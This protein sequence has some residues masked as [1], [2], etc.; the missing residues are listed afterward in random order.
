[1]SNYLDCDFHVC[2]RERAGVMLEERGEGDAKRE[3][4][5]GHGAVFYDQTDPGTEFRLGRRLRERV[6]RNAFN[7]AIH[8][9]DDV[10][11]LF[12]H[13][14]DFLLAR[15]ASGTLTLSIDSRGLKYSFPYDAADADHKSVRSKMVRGDLTGSSFGFVVEKESFEDDGDEIIRTIEAVNPLVDVSPVTFPAFT[16]AD[17]GIKRRKQEHFSRSVAAWIGEH[18]DDA[19]ARKIETRARS[20]FGWELPTDFTPGKP[21]DWYVR[22]L[23]ILELENKIRFG[24][25]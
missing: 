17:S 5:V 7:G 24:G 19:T 21:R 14:D 3:Y 22:Q 10:R 23:H 9:S 11:A 12:N 6:G 18:R 1:M 15:T 25:L 4:I 13:S 8:R 16:A 2:D 20:I